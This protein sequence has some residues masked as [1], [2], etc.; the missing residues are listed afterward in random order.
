MNFELKIKLVWITAGQ[1][2]IQ[3]QNPN[4]NEGGVFYAQKLR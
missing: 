4:S 3:I 2:E 1:T